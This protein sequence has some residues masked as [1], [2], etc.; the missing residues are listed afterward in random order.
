VKRDIN[1]LDELLRSSR[2]PTAAWTLFA[3]VGVGL[4]APVL[5]WG[6]QVRAASRLDPQIVELKTV[7]DRLA[8]DAVQ[9]REAAQARESDRTR[10]AAGA[11]RT[12]GIPWSEALRELSLRVPAGVWLTQFEQIGGVGDSDRVTVRIQGDA[13]SQGGVAELLANLETSRHFTE[14]QLQYSQ[15][16]SGPAGR[17]GFEIQC[18]VPR[19]SFGAPP[20]AG[21]PL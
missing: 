14:P 13:A 9:A 6:I 16:Q 21:R 20:T 12:T 17:V 2:P 15:H 8:Q 4:L 19:A 10:R 11:I 5:I 1:L 7:R 3:V 18:V